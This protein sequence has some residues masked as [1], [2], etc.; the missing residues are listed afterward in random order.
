MLIREG[1]ARSFAHDRRLACTLALIAGSLNSAGFYT[2]G[3]FSANM[4]GNVSTLADE[5]ALGDIITGTFYL[6]IVAAFVLGAVSS[7]LLTAIG[8]RRGIDRIYAFAVLIEALLLALL[9]VADLF[10]PVVARSAVLAFGLSFLMGAQ[11]AI[12]T[13]ISNARV[14]STHVSGMA[15]DVGIE[16][17][18]LIE[19]ALRRAAVGE[20]KPYRDRLGL[21]GV[22]IAA[23]CLG[24]VLGVMAYKAWG[25]WLLFGAAGV[26][27]CL[28]LPASLPRRRPDLVDRV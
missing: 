4:T 17:G 18:H 12:V 8:K 6:A 7:T 1:Q 10:L 3:V 16:I 13:L 2:V 9:G 11:N 14:R 25:A 22:T 27:A 24:G 19:I 23:F 20:A 26:L 5:F 15:T 21:H 28:S